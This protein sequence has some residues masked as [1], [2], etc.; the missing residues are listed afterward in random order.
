MFWGG[1]SD[2]EGKQS[3][4]VVNKALQSKEKGRS[5]RNSPYCEPRPG[6]TPSPGSSRPMRIRKSSQTVVASRENVREKRLGNGRENMRAGRRTGLRICQ[7]TVRRKR[8]GGGGWSLKRTPTQGRKRP[9]QLVE[10][11]RYR[12]A[13]STGPRGGEVRGI[14][15]GMFFG[16]GRNFS[17]FG[18]HKVLQKRSGRNLKKLGKNSRCRRNYIR[19]PFTH[20]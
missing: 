14:R 4:S 8:G 6:T 1:G 9:S 10:R 11:N 16:V 15:R 13:G 18:R 17:S 5:Q 19:T 12:R 20:L 7:V 2:A 3:L